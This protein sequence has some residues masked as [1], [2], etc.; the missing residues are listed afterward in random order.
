MLSLFVIFGCYRNIPNYANSN[1]KV[2][3]HHELQNAPNWVTN[4]YYRDR[5]AA[6]GSNIIVDF[7][8]ESAKKNAIISAKNSLGKTIHTKLY[9]ILQNCAKSASVANANTFSQVSTQVLKP[10]SSQLLKGARHAD[11][12]ISPS[13]KLYALVIIN[14]NSAKSTIKHNIVNCLYQE[15]DLNKASQSNVFLKI[16][17]REIENEFAN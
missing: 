15:R 14:L 10:T 5:I 17:D 6:K 13:G 12:W 7:N 3:D 4:P 8:I 1:S 9:N 11:T 2:Y 16:L